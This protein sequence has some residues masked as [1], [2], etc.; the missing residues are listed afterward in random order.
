[1]PAWSHAHTWLGMPMLLVDSLL[2]YAQKKA[3]HVWPEQ[4]NNFTVRLN[5][6]SP[7]V[8]LPEF[9]P[10]AQLKALLSPLADV[11]VSLAL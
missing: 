6:S 4:A 5:S 1:M 8:H 7:E 11:Q 2:P 10:D 3:V 9:L